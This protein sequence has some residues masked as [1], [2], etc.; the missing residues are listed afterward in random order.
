MSQRILLVEDDWI[1]VHLLKNRL[2]RNGY[3]VVS[4][5]DEADF[6]Q[7]A[8]DLD[9]ALMVV[10]VCLKK[11]LGA[12]IYQMLLDFSEDQKIPVIFTTGLMQEGYGKEVIRDEGYT[13]VPKTIGL[14]YLEEEIERALQKRV[15][16]QAA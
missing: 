16:K 8:F 7:Y 9:L 6:W 14:E 13:F 1:T 5:K 12:M 2:E 15:L 4:A 11:R 10:D 3:E